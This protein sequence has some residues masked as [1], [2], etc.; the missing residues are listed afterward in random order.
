LVVFDC[1][2]N[3]K[4]S[5]ILELSYVEISVASRTAETTQSLIKYL[6][7]ASDI[8]NGLY[9]PSNPDG[10]AYA[11]AKKEFTLLDGLQEF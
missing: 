3:E 10:F 8:R 9:C 7:Y 6:W 11:G 4:G 5:E 2:K 1:E